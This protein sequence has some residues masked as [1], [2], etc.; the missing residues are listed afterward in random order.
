MSIVKIG[1]ASELSAQA[2]VQHLSAMGVFDEVAAGQ[3][4]LN[5]ANS[6]FVALRH[7]GLQA[8]PQVIVLKR[9][10]PEAPTGGIDQAGVQEQV[11]VRK[12]GLRELELWISQG[13][14]LP[15]TR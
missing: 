1:V 5:H 13:T 7:P 10:I 6:H 8:T 9:T 15:A 3:G 4:V 12:V 11:L 2:G 14:P